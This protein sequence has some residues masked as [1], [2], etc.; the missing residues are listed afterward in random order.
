MVADLPG[1][2]PSP[3]HLLATPLADPLALAERCVKLRRTRAAQMRNPP[4][5]V[6]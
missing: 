5:R 4:G 6:R 1:L 3:N 2:N